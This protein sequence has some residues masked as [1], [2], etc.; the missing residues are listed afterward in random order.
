MIKIGKNRRNFIELC[1]SSR[2]KSLSFPEEQT[3]MGV[4]AEKP[5][6]LSPQNYCRVEKPRAVVVQ[7]SFPAGWLANLQPPLLRGEITVMQCP[8]YGSSGCPISLGT[9][10]PGYIQPLVFSS[11]HSSSRL[12]V[13][14]EF[15]CRSEPFMLILRN[16]S[17]SIP[18]LNE[19][20]SKSKVSENFRNTKKKI[21]LEIF[22]LKYEASIINSCRSIHISKSV[23]T[24]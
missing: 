7:P 10:P 3:I 5:E 19:T 16:P 22:F 9:T 8:L 21:F 17:Y 11:S 14:S 12:N 6:E 1:S 2:W 15:R 20:S 4:E 23:Y 13:I 24:V 18:S